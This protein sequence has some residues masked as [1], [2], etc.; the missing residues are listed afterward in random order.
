MKQ[1]IT[2]SIDKDLIRKAKVLAAQQQISISGMLSDEL[3]RVVEAAERYE[4]ARREALQNL[5]KGFHFDGHRDIP[6]ENL[7][8]R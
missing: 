4:L 7:H 1:N 6:R 5:K 8:E 3:K 2:L